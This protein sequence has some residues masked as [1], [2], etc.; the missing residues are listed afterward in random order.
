MLIK[1]LIS[2]GDGRMKER[3]GCNNSEIEIIV[4]DKDGKI[5]EKRREKAHSILF[6]FAWWFGSILMAGGGTVKDVNTG[7]NVNNIQTNWQLTKVEAPSNDDSYGI[8][9]GSGSTPNSLDTYTLASKIQNGTGSGRLVYGS[10]SCDILD[11]SNF[12]T[13]RYKISRSFTNNS[14]GDITV[15]EI[16]LVMQHSPDGSSINARMMICR[17]VLSSPVTVPNGG[18]LYVNYYIRFN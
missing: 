1:K 16:G 2:R 14:G 5:I 11:S 18:I 4:K 6:G 3:G 10:T 12:P 13:M 7:Q 9:V 17:D 15:R 8:W